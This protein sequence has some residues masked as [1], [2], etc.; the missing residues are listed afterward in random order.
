MKLLFSLLLILA[1]SL[2]YFYMD[3]ALTQDE[4]AS[5][6]TKLD[7][8]PVT[9][10]KENLKQMN[11]YSAIVDRPLFI[12]ERR[13]EQEI[14]EKVIRKPTPVIQDFKVQG[15]G[16]ALTGEG[17]I[18]VLKDLKNGDIVRLRIGDGF[19]GWSLKSVSHESFT[20]VKGEAEKVIKFK[21]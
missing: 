6:D 11:A 17:I 5:H 8:K 4:T 21:N 16:I 7:L 10:D 2:T 19:S 1:L 15:L 12:E 18:A 3:Q 14:K 13:F 9:S 20:F